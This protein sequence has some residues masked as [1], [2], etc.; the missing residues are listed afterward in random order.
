MYTEKNRLQTLSVEYQADK[1]SLFPLNKKKIRM[2]QRKPTAIKE[3]V[4]TS[5]NENWPA[6]ATR[7]HETKL[8]YLEDSVLEFMGQI[9]PG[10]N[11]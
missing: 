2:H 5:S 1:T 6:S 10:V 9:K 3:T 8:N 4:K 7:E 11:K